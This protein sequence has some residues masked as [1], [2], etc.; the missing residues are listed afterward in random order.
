LNKKTDEL[1]PKA[2]GSP[3]GACRTDTVKPNEVAVKVKWGCEF[4]SSLRK[5]THAREGNAE[6]QRQHAGSGME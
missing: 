2:A 1:S 3:K 4:A 6:D 5:P